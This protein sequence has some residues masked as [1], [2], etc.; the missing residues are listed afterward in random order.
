[1]YKQFKKRIAKILVKNKEISIIS[2]NCIGADISHGLG[3]Q[4][5][6]PTVNLQ[7]LPCDFSKFVSNLQH[8]M[9]TPLI[10]CTS[11]TEDQN[12]QLKRTYGRKGEQL[13][14]PFGM[15]DDVLVCFQHFKSFEEARD[16][17]IRRSK[18]VDYDNLGIIMVA[19]KTF[20]EELL[21][22]DKVKADKKL[23]FALNFDI[24]LP[25]TRVITVTTPKG[26]HFMEKETAFKKY[27]ERNF[28]PIKWI[29][30]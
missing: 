26:I 21:Q 27:Y 4:F 11:F 15:C 19:D 29:N 2:N 18:R 8:Y 25:N 22:F 3:L 30:S 5:N 10:E 13:E 17:W 7:I 12:V 24:D 23:A 16:A 14:F 20:T 28:N 9:N 6:S 1:M